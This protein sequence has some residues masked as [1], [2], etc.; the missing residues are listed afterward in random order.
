MILSFWIS[1]Y[2]HGKSVSF[3]D[4]MNPIRSMGL[5]YLPA[6]IADFY[7]KL[8]GK[9]N[10]SHGSVMGL[11]FPFM[12]ACLFFRLVTCQ[13]SMDLFPELATRGSIHFLDMFLIPKLRE[14]VLLNWNW[15]RHIGIYPFSHNHGSVEN[16][17][18]WK[19]THIGRTHCP[20]T[21]GGRVFLAKVFLR[22]L[23]WQIALPSP[24]RMLGSMWVCREPRVPLGQV[25]YLTGNDFEKITCE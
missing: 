12:K 2:F 24:A 25:T 1:A 9:Y 21:M 5:V 22:F 4:C 13:N 14:D 20:M 8:V 23:G 3:R 11:E 15:K 19:E 16:K 10:Q 6:W 17:P 18:K 7:G